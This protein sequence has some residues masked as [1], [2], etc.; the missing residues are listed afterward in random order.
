[1]VGIPPSHQSCSLLHHHLAGLS[2]KQ[3]EVDT[4]HVLLVLAGPGSA[5]LLIS[6]STV[7]TFVVCQKP[8][9]VKWHRNRKTNTTQ[10]GE[11]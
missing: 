8:V 2:K 6:I 11:G 10:A 3:F 5:I 1:M 7:V 4:L 9:Y